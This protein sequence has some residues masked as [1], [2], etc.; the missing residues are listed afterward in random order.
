MQPWK[1]IYGPFKGFVI[2]FNTLNVEL[3]FKMIFIMYSGPSL[4]VFVIEIGS[5]F[6]IL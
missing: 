5:F 4:Q 1:Q 2:I 6:N 3:E